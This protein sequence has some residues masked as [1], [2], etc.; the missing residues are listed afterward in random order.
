METR[1][2]MFALT[3][4]TEICWSHLIPMTLTTVSYQIYVP[5]S[6]TRDCDVLAV[7]LFRKQ[8]F[9]KDQYTL[10]ISKKD[11]TANKIRVIN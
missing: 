6:A 10:A 7:S 3:Q 1:R 4:I 11:R 5:Q 8:L 2:A 9:A